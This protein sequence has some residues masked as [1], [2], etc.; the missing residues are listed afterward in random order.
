VAAGSAV[1]GLTALEAGRVPGDRQ[2]GLRT[3]AQLASTGALGVEEVR[4]GVWATEAADWWDPTRW[5]HAGFLAVAAELPGGVDAAYAGALVVTDW[6]A[7]EL[8]GAGRVRLPVTDL[9]LAADAAPA[10]LTD[11][12]AIGVTVVDV[13]PGWSPVEGI[14]VICPGR[15][16]ALMADVGE[17]A[18]WVG[19]LVADLLGRGKATVEEILAALETPGRG[20]AGAERLVQWWLDNAGRLPLPAA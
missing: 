1:P 9:L 18:G 5:H 12:R 15:L 17:D 14:P 6:A 11:V 10:H 3:G 13:M 16:V 2:R 20:R 4:P 7:A 8:R 19:D